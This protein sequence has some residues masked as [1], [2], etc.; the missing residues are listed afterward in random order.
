MKLQRWLI[1]AMLLKVLLASSLMEI[2]AR[3]V[4]SIKSNK[5]EDNYRSGAIR[6]LTG[7]SLWVAG[8]FKEAD[9]EYMAAIASLR[10][11]LESDS[12]YALALRALGDAYLKLRLFSQAEYEL[13]KAI[14]CDSSSAFAYSLLGTAIYLDPLNKGGP[15]LAIQAWQTA[16]NLT[17]DFESAKHLR[18]DVGNVL[19]NE[20]YIE[21]AVPELEEALRLDS[22]CLEARV[23]LANAYTMLGDSARAY[24]EVDKVLQAD[25]TFISAYNTQAIMSIVDNQ[26]MNALKC[27]YFAT[28]YDSRSCRNYQRF[29]RQANW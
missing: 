1:T 15:W 23:S 20:G 18:L 14:R 6:I 17:S 26:F 11:A 21:E 22:S 25:S 10:Q 9:N 5:F 27:Y 28:R 3:T 16:L 2:E 13:K 29:V 7:D 8:K 19:L 4:D 12:C 24:A